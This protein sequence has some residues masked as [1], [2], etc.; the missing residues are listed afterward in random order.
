MI[1]S[2]NVG[3]ALG[4]VR[5]RAPGIRSCSQRVTSNIYKRLAAG[6]GVMPALARLSK[7]RHS[8]ML[9]QLPRVPDGALP[10]PARPSAT[11]SRAN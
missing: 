3:S 10:E 4:Q 6:I 8:W 7:P 9:R 5:G 2:G 1:G 11:Q